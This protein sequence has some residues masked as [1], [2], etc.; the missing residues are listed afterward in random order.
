MGLSERK[1]TNIFYKYFVLLKYYHYLSG[2]GRES[3]CFGAAEV[4]KKNKTKTNEQKKYKKRGD[5][6]INLVYMGS[7]EFK[8]GYLI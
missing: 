8:M 6:Y 5:S 2:P 7:R 4:G 1:I 3:G